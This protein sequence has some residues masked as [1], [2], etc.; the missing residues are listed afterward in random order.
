VGPVTQARILN[1][2]RFVHA[3]GAE[4]PSTLALTF[5]GVPATDL[6]DRIV[7]LRDLWPN[8]DVE[9]GLGYSPLEIRRCVSVLVN[10]LVRR[11]GRLTKPG[12][13]GESAVQL[14]KL[15]PDISLSTT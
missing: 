2:G 1:V 9:R 11:A 3:I 10:D 6:V 8:K 7:P 13:I 15:T 12:L 5:L 14:V 4:F